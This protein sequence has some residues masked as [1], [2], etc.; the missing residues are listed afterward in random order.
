MPQPPGF[1]DIK[2]PNYV[3]KLKKA[4]YGLRWAL[5]AWYT[6]LTSF[7]LNL[8]FKRSIADASLF[9]NNQQSSPMYLIVYVDDIVLTGLNSQVLEDFIKHLAEKFARKDL[10]TLSYFLGVEVVPCK[11]GLFLNQKHY[12]LD[13][14]ERT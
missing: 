14:L 3:C 10:I 5:R 9:I 6:E 2:F 7:L 1:S 8:G 11:Q 4:I 13:L 12:K